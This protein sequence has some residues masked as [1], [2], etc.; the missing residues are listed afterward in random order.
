MRV[1]RR[2]TVLAWRA[3]QLNLAE[4]RPVGGGRGDLRRPFFGELV[5]AVG[6]E[7]DARGLDRSVVAGYRRLLGADETGTRQP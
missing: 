7:V 2:C 5:P 6:E 4:A 3:R 1:G